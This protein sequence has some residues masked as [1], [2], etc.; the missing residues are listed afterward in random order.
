LK[1]SELQSIYLRKEQ[2]FTKF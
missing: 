1:A 2:V